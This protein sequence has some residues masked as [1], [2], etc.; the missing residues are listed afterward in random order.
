MSKTKNERADIYNKRGY[1]KITQEELTKLQDTLLSMYEDIYE[2]CKKYNITPYLCGGS[3]LGAIR[4]KGFIP[5]DDDLDIAMLRKD[6]K[7]FARVFKKELSN[8]YILS[9]PNY[10]RNVKTR[11]PKVIK[12]GTVLQEVGSTTKKGLN[13]IFID[14]FLIDS[15]PDGRFSRLLKG[16]LCNLTQFISSCVYDV[17]YL[18]SE[19][20]LLLK[21]SNKKSYLIRMSVGRLF[22]FVSAESWFN[23]V[24][25]IASSTANTECLG[26]VTGSE[27][28][29]GEIFRREVIIP[30]RYVDFCDI[31]APVFNM[32]RVYLENLYG[33]FMKVPEESERISH[34]IKELKF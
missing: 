27:H 18:D 30:A 4:H 22:S 10:D 5:W 28:Y 6:Y 16:S 1:H 21:K 31:K 29:F 3:A 23:V 26:L 12:R 8:K 2:V 15:V 14:I 13:G 25:S 34:N 17:Q 11:F 32:V 33:D 9:A 7:K 19:C 24:D 20:K